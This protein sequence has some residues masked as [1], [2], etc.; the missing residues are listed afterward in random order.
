MGKLILD[1]VHGNNELCS[2]RV[3]AMRVAAAARKTR[4]LSDV[5]HFLEMP[6]VST[7]HVPAGGELGSASS[8]SVGD[9]SQQVAKPT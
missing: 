9:K 7:G 3:C 4:S 6:A 1:P 8:G 2:K 5:D